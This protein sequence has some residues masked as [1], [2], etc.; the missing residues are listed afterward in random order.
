MSHQ[1][2][3]TE[4]DCLNCGTLVQGRFC[5][6]CGQE[7]IIPKETFFSLVKH[8]VYD[9]LHF[10][11]KFFDTIKYV[12]FRPG[13]LSKLYVDGKRASFLHPIRMYL[14]TSAVFFLVFFSIEKSE[15]GFFNFDNTNTTISKEARAD[16][17]DDLQKELVKK[18]GDTALSNKLNRL[19]DTTQRV[20]PED[21][22]DAGN[23]QLFGTGEKSYGS[24]AQYDSFQKTVAATERDGWLKRRFIKKGL[25]LNDRYRGNSMAGMK[26][27]AELFMH[28]LPYLLFV[29]LP[30]F[31]LVLKLLYI[32]RK[33]YYYSDHAVF[34][35]HHYIF[36]FILLLIAFLF[37]ALTDWTGVKLF[38]NLMPVF[39]IAWAVYL[40]LAMRRFY[41]QGRFKTFS[42]FFLLNMLGLVVLLLLFVQFLFF[43]F[44]QL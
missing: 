16:L 22:N 21:I 43:T 39:I 10:D 20:K 26:V 33:N 6:V 1:P 34:T 31:A 27:F 3:R 2:E 4:K 15:S 19:R 36:S 17:I 44:F 32:R 24:I 7:N 25:E 42:K 11:S 38:K 35:S 30:F 23:W 8:F 9:I 18:P 5:H 41:G 37:T 40:F 12:L 28:K 13:Y 29:S 14:F